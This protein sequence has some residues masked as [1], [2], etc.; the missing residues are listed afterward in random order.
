MIGVLVPPNGWEAYLGGGVLSIVAMMLLGVPLYVCASASVPIAAGLIHAGASPGA[1]LAF[2]ISG[3][4]SNPATI[5]TVWKLL[6]RR[7]ALLYLLAVAI[8]AIGGGL[9]LDWLMPALHAVVP[10]LSVHAHQAMHAD[11]LTVFWA[12][13]LLAVFVDSYAEKPRP[14]PAAVA[15]ADC[16]GHSQSPQK[17]LDLAIDGMTCGH[18]ARRSAVR[19]AAAAT[20]RPSRS[21]WRP[22]GPWWPATACKSMNSSPPSSPPAI[23]PVCSC[24]TAANRS[25]AA[26]IT[27]CRLPLCVRI[28]IGSG[29]ST[30]RSATSIAMTPSAAPPTT[31]TWCGTRR[32]PWWTR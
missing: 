18:C 29:P 26:H 23:G 3:P 24:S 17:R 11:W 14:S 31:P 30:G 28:S 15:E 12:V 6:G 32:P 1:A 20:W 16:P 27:P 9:L 21:I 25:T 10:P 5:T 7:T 4:A 22:A 8:S 19:Y 2:L 13:L